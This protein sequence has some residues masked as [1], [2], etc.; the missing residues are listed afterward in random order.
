MRFAFTT[1]LA[2]LPI[3]GVAQ[4]QELETIPHQGM[5]GDEFYVAR[6]AALSFCPRLVLELGDP[7]PADFGLEREAA[8]MAPS[9]PAPSERY[10]GRDFENH[11]V[12]VVYDPEAGEC[13]TKV[14]WT[15]SSRM[16]TY[17]SIEQAVRREDFYRHSQEDG[18]SIYKKQ[19]ENGYPGL[20]Y[21]LERDDSSYTVRFAVA[22]QE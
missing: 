17:R 2:F 22:E 21:I 8:F 13:S 12:T 15:A 5:S 10:F 19:P 20:R 6:N 14:T 11:G 3:A 9:G 4:A 7:D 18:I 16:T 1:L